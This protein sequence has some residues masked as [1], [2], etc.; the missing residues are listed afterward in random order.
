MI[1][2]VKSSFVSPRSSS[3][4][5]RVTLFS[6][7]NSP[8]TFV[9]STNEYRVIPLTQ[10]GNSA[11][12]PMS[13]LLSCFLFYFKVSQVVRERLTYVYKVFTL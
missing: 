5:N 11:T 7:G 1:I 4:T 12:L 9:N 10:G 3:F 8:S 13:P 6:F 2:N